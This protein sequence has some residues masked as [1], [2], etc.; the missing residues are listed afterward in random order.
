MERTKA[1]SVIPASRTPT[2][3]RM[4]ASGRCCRKKIFGGAQ[5]NIDFKMRV[6]SASSIQK[7][8]PYDSIVAVSRMPPTFSTPS[9]KSCLRDDVGSTS[10]VP[11]IAA[12]LLHRPSWQSR[13]MS[14]R[15]QSSKQGPMSWMDRGSCR[16]GFQTRP[17]ATD[18]AHPVAARLLRARYSQ[19]E[20]VGSHSRLHREQS[21]AAGG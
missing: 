18:D 1:I 20:G 8:H 10:G 5:S 2:R 15:M 21:C 19:R 3:G 13:A 11:Q 6:E 14:G 12:D 4:T 9:V 17:G 16:G 7:M